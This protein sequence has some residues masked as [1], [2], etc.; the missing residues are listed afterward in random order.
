MRSSSVAV[1]AVVALAI[2]TGS[3]FT[4]RVSN[5]TFLPGAAN[6]RYMRVSGS[7]KPPL[8]HD[9]YSNNCRPSRPASYH[10]S[11]AGSGDPYD[12]RLYGLASP[13]GGTL[14]M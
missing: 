3:S 1:S 13:F 2:T 8:I 5:L 7:G 4:T 14:L 11:R 12:R 9:N 6:S 10:S